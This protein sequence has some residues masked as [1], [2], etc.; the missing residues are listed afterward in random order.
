M[1]AQIGEQGIC[2][3][4][5]KNTNAVQTTVLVFFSLR[6]FPNPLEDP[7][8]QDMGCAFV[9]HAMEIIIWTFPQEDSAAYVL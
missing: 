1:K 5:C 9:T 4:K 3:Y 6:N 2:I 7:Y 8:L